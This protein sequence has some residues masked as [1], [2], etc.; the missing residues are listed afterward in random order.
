MPSNVVDVA[1][2]CRNP[3]GPLTRIAGGL[4]AGAPSTVKE[5]VS[6][7]EATAM[8]AK[9]KEAGADAEMK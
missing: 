1:M 9:L 6:K 2:V 8:V 7:D 5:G 4:L 3:L